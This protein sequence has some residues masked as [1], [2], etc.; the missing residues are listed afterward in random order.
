MQKDNFTVFLIIRRNLHR[1]SINLFA[2]IISIA[3]VTLEIVGFMR[4]IV[5]FR[6]HL[7]CEPLSFQLCTA[8]LFFVF[9]VFFSHFKLKYIYF[10]P[11]CFYLCVNLRRPMFRLNIARKV[12]TAG[13]HS[14]GWFCTALQLSICPKSERI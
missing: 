8:V 1:F 12:R 7:K 5:S 3:C 11:A 9:F 10:I 2:L 4:K 6:F 13:S 14:T